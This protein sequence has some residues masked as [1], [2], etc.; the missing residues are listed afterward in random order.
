MPEPSQ[1]A[2]TVIP[3]QFKVPE[4]EQQ[5]SSWWGRYKANAAR[6]LSPTALEVL[7]VDARHIV[8][9]AL[10][11]IDG[12]IDANAWPEDGL[13]TGMVIGSVQSGKTASMLAVASLA[14]D[15]GVDIVILLA[16][17]RVGL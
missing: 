4:P 11:T 1:S 12:A 2:I 5:P 8:E 14:L 17:T 15:Q 9:R 3:A 6:Q 16:G 10:P 13:R 7:E